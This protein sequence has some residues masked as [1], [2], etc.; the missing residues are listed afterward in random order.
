MVPRLGTCYGAHRCLLLIPLIIMFLPFLISVSDLRSLVCGLQ[1][2]GLWSAVCDLWLRFEKKVVSV[3]MGGNFPPKTMG[4][5]G[6]WV[7]AD[8]IILPE[9]TLEWQMA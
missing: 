9:P 6:S 7:R 4:G 5:R 1:V 2:S 8:C 3:Y